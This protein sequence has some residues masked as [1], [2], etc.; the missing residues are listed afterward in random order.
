[1][2]SLFVEVFS[3][4]ALLNTITPL[5][6]RLDTFNKEALL[7]S[8]YLRELWLNYLPMSLGVSRTSEYFTGEVNYCVD[9]HK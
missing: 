7:Q 1:M 3:S 8:C 6:S 5:D 9:Y 2:L 4:M